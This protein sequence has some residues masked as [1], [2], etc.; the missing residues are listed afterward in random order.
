[1][2]AYGPALPPHLKKTQ[3]DETTESSAET[4]VD[5]KSSSKPIIGPALPPGLKINENVE[6]DDTNEEEEDEEIGPLPP[7]ASGIS[8]VQCELEERA[9]EIKLN[10]G[11]EGSS[12]A[13]VREEW[14]LSLPEVRKPNSI[15]TQARQFSKK[16]TYDSLADR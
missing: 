14:M 16:S 11:N 4:Q 2:D 15:Q 6:N 7:G 3:S 10:K 9:L 8:R 12:D 1:M 13:Q 5:E